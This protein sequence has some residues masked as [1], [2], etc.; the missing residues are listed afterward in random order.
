MVMFTL[1]NITTMNNSVQKA[2]FWLF[3]YA[4]QRMVYSQR[5]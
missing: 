4:D 1:K 2:A 5:G 3:F